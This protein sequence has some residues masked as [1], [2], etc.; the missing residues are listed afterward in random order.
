LRDFFN[1]IIITELQLYV[2]LKHKGLTRHPAPKNGFYFTE[3]EH[4]ITKLLQALRSMIGQPGQDP[5]LQSRERGSEIVPIQ[6]LNTKSCTCK[7][8]I[9]FLSSFCPASPPPTAAVAT[10]AAEAAVKAGVLAESRPHPDADVGVSPPECRVNGTT[11]EKEG[12][13][14]V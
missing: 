5:R 11:P 1:K 12:M 4:D 13:G 2:T 9:S 3:V 10:A 14:L 8:A 7:L 6:S